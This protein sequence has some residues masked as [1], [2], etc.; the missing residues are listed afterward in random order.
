MDWATINARLHPSHS[1]RNST[2]NNRPEA[3][4]RGC[5]RKREHRRLLVGYQLLEEVQVEVT[6]ADVVT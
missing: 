5:G 1:F 6:L 2:Q 4:K 3:A